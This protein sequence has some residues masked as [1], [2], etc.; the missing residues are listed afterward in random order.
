M[1]TFFPVS[2]RHSIS[3]F[4][5]RLCF[6]V[7]RNVPGRIFQILSDNIC[8]NRSEHVFI[9]SFIWCISLNIATLLVGLFVLVIIRKG[10]SNKSVL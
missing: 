1:K 7:T 2:V 8:C 6:V 9:W 5:T 3:V 10:D 4:N